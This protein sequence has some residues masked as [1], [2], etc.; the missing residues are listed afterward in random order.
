VPTYQYRC[1]KWEKT[2]DQRV[3]GSRRKMTQS[4]HY[5]HTSIS[6]RSPSMMLWEVGARPAELCL[7]GP[8]EESGSLLGHRWA[9]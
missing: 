3:V 5:P 1:E 9:L 7:K 8:G 6:M 4:G 2:F